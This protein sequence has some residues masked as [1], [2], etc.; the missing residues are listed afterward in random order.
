MSRDHVGQLN[1]LLGVPIAL[2]RAA[3]PWALGLL[4]S[5]DGGYAVGLRWVLLCSLLSVVALWLAQ[6]R[7]LR[8]QA[9]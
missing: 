6:A 5:A 4:W 3:A 7:A 2:A 1:G 8:L 9:R